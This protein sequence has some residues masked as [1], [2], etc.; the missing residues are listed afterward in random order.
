VK[1]TKRQLRRIIGEAIGRPDSAMEPQ[2]G[3]PR[4]SATGPS[5]PASGG[6]TDAAKEVDHS[7]LEIEGI[8]HAD[9]PDYVDAFFSYGSYANGI[10]MTDV[11]LQTFQENNPDL[12]YEKLNE[13]LY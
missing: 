12:F 4:R 3:W 6:E 8:D 9:H 5:G 11:E 13:F 10:E 7:S 2:G 1:I